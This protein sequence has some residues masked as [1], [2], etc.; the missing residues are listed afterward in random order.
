L[1]FRSTP[2][3]AIV[4]ILIYTFIVMLMAVVIAFRPGAAFGA[5]L[6]TFGL[7]QWAQSQSSFF[8]NY[9]WLT[10]VIFA[11]MMVEALLIKFVRGEKVWN[12]FTREYGAMLAL[13]AWATLSLLWTVAR[14]GERNSFTEY[15]KMLPYFMLFG[16][17]SPLVI[18]S[19]KDVRDSIWL[20][21]TVGGTLVVM[22]LFFATWSGRS[23]EMNREGVVASVISERAAPL[24]IGSLAGRIA[25]VAVLLSWTVT[26][27][28]W[29]IL[30]L[31]LFLIAIA[32]AVTIKS[33]SRGQALALVFCVLAFLPLTLKVKNLGSV[34]G[35]SLIAAILVLAGWNTFESFS[36]TRNWNTD[37][38][39]DTYQ[40]TRVNMSQQLLTYWADTNPFYWLFGLGSSASFKQDIVG[41]YPHVVFFEVLGELGFIGWFLLWLTPIFAF[42]TTYKLW[43]Y[44][45]ER[46]IERGLVMAVSAMFLYD[47]ILSFKQGSLLGNSSAFGLAAVLGRV[48]AGYRE[49]EKQY[50]LMEQYADGQD[51][52]MYD[53]SQEVLDYEY[54]E[55]R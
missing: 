8:L 28:F 26:A 22:L 12:P 45:S 3:A 13:Y 55:T 40:G 16:F 27:R 52:Q 37:T 38:F 53:E 47:V 44:V 19:I 21:M 10:N 42:H 41:F 54:A 25:L 4:P 15:Q 33:G 24:A 11:M 5:M 49:E 29:T 6:C 43:D 7:E 1:L 23:I 20:L 46:P 51:Y 14:D 35:L 17:I 34:F 48:Y 50:L 39:W 30:P 32:M 18:Q 9:K 31:R 36:G 2:E